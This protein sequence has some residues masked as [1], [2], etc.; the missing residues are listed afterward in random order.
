MS[1]SSVFPQSSN[2]NNASQTIRP[3]APNPRSNPAIA[4]LE[5]R[6][7]LQDEAELEFLE[8]GKRGHGGRQFLDIYTVRQMLVL[9]DEKRQSAAQIEKALGLKAGS[10]DRLGSPGVVGIAQESIGRQKVEMV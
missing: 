2:P 8:A 10:V 3:S 6:S 1:E 7:K 4:V 9:R 5:S